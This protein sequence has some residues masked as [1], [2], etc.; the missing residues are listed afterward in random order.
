MPIL[1]EEEQGSQ[2]PR[3][4]ARLPPS[5]IY[6][7]N[8]QSHSQEP[9]AA[10]LTA[11]KTAPVGS[12]SSPFRHSNRSTG[13]INTTPTS[14]NIAVRAR[15]FSTSNSGNSSSNNTVGRSRSFS[16]SGGV[17]PRSRAD[18]EASRLAL[19]AMIQK[20]LDRI[21]QRLDEFNFQSY[22][23]YARTQ[24]LEKSFQD[25]AKRLYKVEDHL[26]RVQGKPGLSD[27]YL[28]NGG[29]PQPRRL[30]HDLE[31]LRMGVK[32][33]RKKFQVAGSVVSTVEWW[34]RMKDGQENSGNSSSS[35]QAHAD[36]SSDVLSSPPPSSPTPLSASTPAVI[37]GESRSSSHSRTMSRKEGKALQRIMTIPDAT[38]TLHPL[39]PSGQD[40]VSSPDSLHPYPHPALGLR[41]PPL[42]P[43]CP[44]TLLGSFLSQRSHDDLVHSTTTNIKARPL[45]VIHDLEE[46]P[47]QLPLTPPTSSAAGWTK[48]TTKSDTAPTALLSSSSMADDIQLDNDYTVNAHSASMVQSSPQSN[49]NSKEE[50]RPVLLEIFTPPLHL[51][52]HLHASAAAGEEESEVDN[53]LRSTEPKPE[54]EI[55]GV[56]NHAGCG[57]DEAGEEDEDEA[58]GDELQGNDSDTPAM[59]A[60]DYDTKEIRSEELT[61]ADTISDSTSSTA[62]AATTIQ[63]Q[64]EVSKDVD[65]FPNTFS[66]PT[67]Q[68]AEEETPETKADTWI[69]TVWRILIRLEYLLLGTAVLGAMMPE[70]LLALC[71]GFLSAILYG[72]LVIRHRFLAAPDSEAPRP[73]VGSMSMRRRSGKLGGGRGL[74]GGRVGRGKRSCK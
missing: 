68:Q 32:T 59:R 4:P 60:S 70:S 25:N 41:S 38:S 61:A 27:A 58:E 22:D 12:S 14:N 42:T 66:S 45:S 28:E 53:V 69:Q 29:A 9:A 62:F 52:L 43:K 11:P 36:E 24:A 18:S 71:A 10:F 39:P 74:G 31:E 16:T 46:P 47:L 8:T 34:K 1:L 30:T 15:S 56:E 65:V 48:D 20:R 35:A 40:T 54:V 19:E 67:K 73:P 3:R 21:T 7:V 72:A 49:T 33:L 55:I 5:R 6:T 26:L 13:N 57:G 17:V 44:P 51:H 63:E 37:S 2:H 23:L 50:S 64:A